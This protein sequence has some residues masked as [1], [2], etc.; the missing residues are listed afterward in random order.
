MKTKQKVKVLVISNPV[1]NTV[2]Y[3]ERKIINALQVPD[4]LLKGKQSN[5]C[6]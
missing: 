2:N 3:F 1:R 4:K 5:T 6:N